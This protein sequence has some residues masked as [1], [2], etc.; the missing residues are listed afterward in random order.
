MWGNI[1]PPKA[2]TPEPLGSLI[3]QEIEY[4]KLYVIVYKDRYE[5]INGDK[6][7]LL[8]GGVVFKDFTNGCIEYFFKPEIILENGDIISGGRVCL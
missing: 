5:L 2:V 7:V 6:Q 3:W 1:P 4:N 8:E